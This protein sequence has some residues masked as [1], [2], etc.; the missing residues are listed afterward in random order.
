VKACT[1]QKQ[2]TLSAQQQKSFECKVTQE[3]QI[4]SLTA[5]LEK[6]SARLAL[7]KSRTQ[8]VV[9]DP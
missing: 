6:V 2:E 9:N 7:S 1:V 8:T 4:E 5:G 3:K